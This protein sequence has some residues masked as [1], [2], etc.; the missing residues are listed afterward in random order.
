MYHPKS[1]LLKI[2]VACYNQIN[3]DPKFLGHPWL[4]EVLRVVVSHLF[5]GWNQQ[6]WSLFSLFPSQE[7]FAKRRGK[8]ANG[9]HGSTL[10]I[11]SWYK[12]GPYT[13]Q[14]NGVKWGPLDGLINGYLE[15]HPMTRKWL[16][17]IVR[18]SPKWGG[19]GVQPHLQLLK[20]Q[21]VVHWPQY[22]RLGTPSKTL[23]PYQRS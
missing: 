20:A 3:H 2:Q 12:V 10:T 6:F 21:L 11:F 17:T 16:I 13:I 8:K 15:D 22:I 1:S 4:T 23:V 18:K 9:K 7:S 19:I 5:G 14:T